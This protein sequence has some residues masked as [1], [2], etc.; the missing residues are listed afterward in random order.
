M[1]FKS[2]RRYSLLTVSFCSICLQGIPTLQWK[3]PYCIMSIHCAFILCTVQFLL[4]KSSLT[5]Y[6]HVRFLLCW[7]STLSHLLSL[8]I[9]PKFQ[10]ASFSCTSFFVQNFLNLLL[11]NSSGVCM[12]QYGRWACK[13]FYQCL[14]VVTVSLL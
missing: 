4:S 8:L 7:L 9:S 2:Q 14:A 10:Q 3:H 13:A 1:F 11:Q 5:L 12:L 6:H